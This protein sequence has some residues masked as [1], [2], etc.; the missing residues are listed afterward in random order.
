MKA[1]RFRQ[2]GISDPFSDENVRNFFKVFFCAGL[3]KDHQLNEL[4][5][6]EVGG[7]IRSIIGRCS[8]LQ[9][10]PLSSAQSHKMN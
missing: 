8:A 9:D 7:T 10:R 6:L 3:T 4:R 1:Q 5:F 2:M